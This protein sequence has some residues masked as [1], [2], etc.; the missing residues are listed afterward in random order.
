MAVGGLVAATGAVVGGVGVDAVGHELAHNLESDRSGK[1]VVGGTALVLVGLVF[2]TIGITGV[3]PWRPG[4]APT[5]DVLG[6]PS[7]LDGGSTRERPPLETQPEVVR[8]AKQVRSA[9]LRHECDAAWRTLLALD[10]RDAVYA[11][12]L[13]QSSV[14]QGCERTN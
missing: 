1:M 4:P 11:S 8:L 10:L 2:L 14:M 3:E 12:V 7:S 13:A 5:M 6:P 9:V